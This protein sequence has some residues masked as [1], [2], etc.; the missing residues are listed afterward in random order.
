MCLKS[1]F[2]IREK[3]VM[4]DP[5]FSVIENKPEWRQF[6]KKEWYDGKEKGISEVEYYISSGNIEEAA[7]ISSS[8]SRE[9]PGSSAAVYAEALVNLAGS[10]FTEAGKAVT[11]LLEEEPL[12]EKYLRLLSKT[13]EASGNFTGAS[14]TYTKLIGNSVVD[15]GLLILR[16]ECYRKTGEIDKAIA[17]IE[18]YLQFYP[19]S[20]KAISI[21]GKLESAGGDN[22]KAMEYF[23]R[24][25]KL[26]PSDAQC[27]IDR[28]NSYF[29]SRS[30]DWAIK[31]YSMSLDLQPANPEA[32][33]N[34]GIAL[35][36]SGKVNDACFD[37]RRSFS[38]GN[39]KATDYISRN[40]I[41]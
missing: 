13:Q 15:A 14:N 39:K 34:K 3:D 18:K 20:Q 36:N 23:S 21:A 2:K 28:A 22:L 26:H 4:L 12:N 5:S 30:W 35:L 1:P 40:C 11:S 29:I 10:K 33:L 31:D 19:E 27:Y 8:I 37:F 6:W 32:W 38:Y 9:Y 7:N 16:S 41:K 24:N 17:D 25:L